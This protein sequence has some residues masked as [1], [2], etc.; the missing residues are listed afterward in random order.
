MPKPRGRSTLVCLKSNKGAS[1]ASGQGATR[2]IR[3]GRIRGAWRARSHTAL[4]VIM[5]ALALPLRKEPPV[6]FEQ[7][8]N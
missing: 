1:V 2:R 6:S 5:L 3:R 8:R 4:K 7:R